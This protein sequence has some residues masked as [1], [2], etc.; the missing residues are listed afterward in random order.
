MNRNNGESPFRAML[1]GVRAQIYT[2]RPRRDETRRE[3]RGKLLTTRVTRHNARQVP[4]RNFSWGWGL[5]AGVAPL[6][7]FFFFSSERSLGN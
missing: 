5:A 4:R 7:F 6:F 1:L 2:M 3:E